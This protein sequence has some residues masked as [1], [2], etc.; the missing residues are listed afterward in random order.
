MIAKPNKPLAFFP[1]AHHHTEAMFTLGNVYLRANAQLAI[2][3]LVFYHPLQT[4]AQVKPYLVRLRTTTKVYAYDSTSTQQRALPADLVNHSKSTVTYCI[5]L[6]WMVDGRRTFY[7]KCFLFNSVW[8]L[9]SIDSRAAQTF[10][11]FDEWFSSR[12]IVA[13][14]RQKAFL[15]KAELLS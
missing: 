9:H 2:C 4:Q 12:L 13:L 11:G 1:S 15:W 14:S 3:W 7:A 6:L 5:R 10:F 8:L